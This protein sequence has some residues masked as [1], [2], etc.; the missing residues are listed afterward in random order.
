MSEHGLVCVRPQDFSMVEHGLVCEPVHIDHWKNLC[1]NIEITLF[2]HRLGTQA[3][4][5]SEHKS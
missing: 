4:P 5:V 1:P 2:G 3:K